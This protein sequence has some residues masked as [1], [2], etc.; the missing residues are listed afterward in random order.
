MSE[1]YSSMAEKTD[2]L[3]RAVEVYKQAIKK[4][5]AFLKETNC[6][7]DLLAKSIPLQEN[8]DT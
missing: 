1:I 7:D 3:K 2:N 5:F 8:K 4:E 6:F